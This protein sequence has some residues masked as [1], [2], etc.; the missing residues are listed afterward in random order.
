MS[1]ISKV[2]GVVITDLFLLAKACQSL[3]LSLDTTKKTYKSNWTEKI[4]CAAVVSNNEET[5]E[6][7]IVQ[8]EKGYEIQW[9]SYHNSLRDVIGNNCE[10]ICRS[11]ATEA[12]LQQA[13]MAGMVNST[14]IQEDGSVVI[15]GVFI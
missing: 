8:T 9:D 7:A 14:E 13:G 5:G 11:Y 15:E 10:T 3:G 6:A 2:T 1:H 12:V 4:D